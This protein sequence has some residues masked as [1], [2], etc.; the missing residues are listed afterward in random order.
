[1]KPAFITGLPRSRT[2][3]FVQYLRACGVPAH[4]ELMN[5]IPCRESFYSRMR[6][7][8]VDSDCGLIMSDFQR[9]FPGAPCVIIHRNIGDVWSSLDEFNAKVG[10]DRPCI[11]KLAAMRRRLETLDGLHVAFHDINKRIEEIHN[12]LGSGVEFNRGLADKMVLE[13]HQVDPVEYRIDMDSVRYWA[14]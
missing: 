1:M 5:G 8:C 3:W 7:G 4:H 9:E 10:L 13:N 2:Y 6:E 12:Y 14:A 11:N